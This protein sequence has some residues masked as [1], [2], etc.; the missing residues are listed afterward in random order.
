M[1][2]MLDLKREERLLALEVLR[3]SEERFR[4]LS[5]LSS[6][7]Y[8]EQDDQYRFT[9][10]SGNGPEW[11]TEWARQV[12][13]KKRWDFNCINMTEEGWAA[14]VALLDARQ[15]F[16]DFELC[17]LHESGKKVWVSVSGEPVF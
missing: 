14:H 5:Q 16:H 8:W 10:A 9:S 17:T 7:M 1:G 12:V 3:K 11:M 2:R 13:G 6:D 15:P 4:S